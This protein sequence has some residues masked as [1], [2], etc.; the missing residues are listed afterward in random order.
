MLCVVAMEMAQPLGTVLAHKACLLFDTLVLNVAL[1]V[2]LHLQVVTHTT[3]LPLL[4][5]TLD[6]I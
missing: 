5:R 1:V 4:V 2:R 6:N 3:R